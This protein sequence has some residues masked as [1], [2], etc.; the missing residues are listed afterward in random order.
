M[1]LLEKIQ[2]QPESTRKIILWIAV[3][4]IGLAL[5]LFWLYITKVQI[6]NFQK[7]KFFEN[8]GMPDFNQSMQNIPAVELPATGTPELSE[9]E[10]K[11]LEKT[12]QEAK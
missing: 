12:L 2:K 8:I 6:K 7:G 10:L 9:Q 4:I 1:A 3:I 5:F 11:E